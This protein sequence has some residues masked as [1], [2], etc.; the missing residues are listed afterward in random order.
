MWGGSGTNLHQ[1]VTC[2]PLGDKRNSN[3]EI[4]LDIQLNSEGRTFHQWVTNKLSE[5]WRAT[6]FT[7][8]FS[9]RLLALHRP[10]MRMTL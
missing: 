8:S 5:K 1:S 7:S 4:T 3:G 6:S 2:L 10:S 9:P